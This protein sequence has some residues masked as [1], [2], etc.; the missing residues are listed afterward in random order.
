MPAAKRWKYEERHC[1]CPES[2]QQ[3][4]TLKMEISK[5][6]FGPAS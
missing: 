1:Y 5:L 6:N 2:L 4:F 3:Q